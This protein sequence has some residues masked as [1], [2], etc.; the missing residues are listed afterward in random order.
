MI[1]QYITTDDFWSWTII[2]YSLPFK[3]EDDK[4][5]CKTDSF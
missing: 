2:M 1:P 5:M 4:Y 3:K